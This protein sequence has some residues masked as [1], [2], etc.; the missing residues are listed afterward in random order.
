MILVIFEFI[1][2]K[3]FHNQPKTLALNGQVIKKHKPPVV[4][5]ADK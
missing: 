4:Q 5:C 2:C 3:V 1:K